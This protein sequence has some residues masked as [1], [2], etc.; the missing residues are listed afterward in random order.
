[1]TAEEQD[2]NEAAAAADAS[3]PEAAE[4]AAT[5]GSEPAVPADGEEQAEEQA[6]E[7]VEQDLEELQDP[8]VE[9][10]QMRE[11]AQRTQADFENFRKRARQNE[12]LAGDR[13]VAKLAR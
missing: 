10:A 2:A 5:E 1:M 7:E 3:A 4:P 11:L 8:A 6:A 9:A 12:Q 13:G